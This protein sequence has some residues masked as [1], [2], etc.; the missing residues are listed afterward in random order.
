MLCGFPHSSVGK[1]STCN[2]GD[3][4]SIPGWGRSAGEGT[5][6]PLQYS[7]TSFV[8]RL[9]ENLA[10]KQETWV[11]SLGW[12]GPLEKGKATHSSILAWTIPWTI[13]QGVT[14]SRRRLS[15]F[16]FHSC[17]IMLLLSAHI[18]RMLCLHLCPPLDM[19]VS[20]KNVRAHCKPLTIFCLT[21]FYPEHVISPVLVPGAVT[22]AHLP[23]I[24]SSLLTMAHTENK[25]PVPSP[26]S[27][28]SHICGPWVWPWIPAPLLICNWNMPHY[29]AP[30]IFPMLY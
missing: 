18:L 23:T 5:G 1:E 29:C 19:R 11:Q 27:S 8:A 24:K 16:H 28:P 15:D 6:Y 21:E 2:A 17:S 10:A 22:V 12:E 30:Q 20:T 7:W 3:H 9:V 26:V 4:G 25:R 14:K 13:V